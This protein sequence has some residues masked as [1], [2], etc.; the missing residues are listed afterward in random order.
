MR[1]LLIAPVPFF[2]LLLLVA[3]VLLFMVVAY[4]LVPSRARMPNRPADAPEV[5]DLKSSRV[6]AAIMIVIEPEK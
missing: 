5:L 6:S 1:D 2:Y 4:F 3:A